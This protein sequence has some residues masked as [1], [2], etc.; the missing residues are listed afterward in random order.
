LDCSNQKRVLPFEGNNDVLVPNQA[1]HYPPS[2]WRRAGVEVY[3]ECQ[4]LI[5]HRHGGKDC[6]HS[7]ASISAHIARFASNLTNVLFV[8]SSAVE[9]C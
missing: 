6:R 2:K 1:M 9:S 5:E 7:F 8:F 3:L 4:L